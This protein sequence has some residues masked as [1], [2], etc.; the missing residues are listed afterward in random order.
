MRHHIS[1][2]DGEYTTLLGY[3]YQVNLQLLLYS[4]MAG[5]EG[6]KLFL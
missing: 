4:I 1:N 5:V 3:N 2:I 6:V